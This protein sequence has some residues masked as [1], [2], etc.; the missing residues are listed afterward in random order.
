MEAHYLLLQHGFRIVSSYGIATKVSLAGETRATPNE[1]R[2]GTPYST[3]LAD[4][5]GKNEAYY[6]RLRLTHMIE[7]DAKVK[8]C[9]ERFQES[10]NARFDLVLTYEAHVY[11]MV[12]D[13][14][15]SRTSSL[16]MPVH[17]VNLE[18]PDTL[19]EAAAASLLSL[20]LVRALHAAMAGAPAGAA[21]AEGDDECA[22]AALGRMM[23]HLPPP[24][25]DLGRAEQAQWEGALPMLLEA[26]ETETKKPVHHTVV[27]V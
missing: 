19:E 4:L 17:V 7:R 25:G 27:W 2:F 15:R 22:E 10:S 1:Y 26:I 11:N 12:L 9:P 14:L 6:D 23:A 24:E 5:R 16:L 3:I 21:A 18:T 20:R 13:D 8:P